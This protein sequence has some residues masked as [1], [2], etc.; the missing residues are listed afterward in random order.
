MKWVAPEALFHQKNFR[1][2]TRKSSKTLA[3]QMMQKIW[4]WST[5]WLPKPQPSECTW[6]LKPF[7]ISTTPLPGREFTSEDCTQYPAH[8]TQVH[9]PCPSNP[10]LWLQAMCTACVPQKPITDLDHFWSPSYISALCLQDRTSSITQQF[11]GSAQF[12]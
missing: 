2:N 1:T 10:A 7:T 5:L 12:R 3:P 11:Q 9:S 6:Q 8:A 4:M